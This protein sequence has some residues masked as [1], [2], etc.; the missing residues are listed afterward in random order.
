MSI[1]GPRPEDWDL[2]QQHYTPQQRRTLEVRPGIASP[3]DV[4]WYPDLT[5]H[6]PPPPNVSIQQHY[7]TRHL[8][9][10]LAESLRYVERQSLLLDLKVICQLM[11]CVLVR[12][13]LPPTKQPPTELEGIA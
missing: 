9:V 2:V 13:W 12:S 10:Q 4:R 7:L 5:Y 8:P 6:D 3:A 11:Y 1:V